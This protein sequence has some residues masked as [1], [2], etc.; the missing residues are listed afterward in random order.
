VDGGKKWTKFDAASYNVCRRAKHGKLV[1]LAGNGGKIA[2]F[3][4]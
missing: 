3:K 2:L 1:L 4:P